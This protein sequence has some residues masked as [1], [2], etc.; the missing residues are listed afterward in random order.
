M[1]YI[2]QD[3]GTIVVDDDGIVWGEYPSLPA[4]IADLT[5]Q[6]NEEQE[7]IDKL[8][9]QMTDAIE[10]RDALSELL[11]TMAEDSDKKV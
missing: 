6:R 7:S 9:E 11:D 5:K 1:K 4:A 3:D 10:L 8:Q 2:K